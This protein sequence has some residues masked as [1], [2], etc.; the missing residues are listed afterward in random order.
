MA[1]R[2]ENTNTIPQLTDGSYSLTMSIA[3]LAKI[4]AAAAQG[5]IGALQKELHEIAGRQRK[6][7]KGRGELRDAFDGDPRSLTEILNEILAAIP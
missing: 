5:G 2:F 4:K 7:S 1:W 3:E 6:P